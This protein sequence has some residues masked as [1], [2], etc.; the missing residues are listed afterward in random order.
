MNLPHK[1]HKFFILGI[2]F[3][4][5]MPG[6]VGA[7][8]ETKT[9]QI[10]VNYSNFLSSVLK[11]EST[12]GDECKT[13][14]SMWLYQGGYDKA[15]ELVERDKNCYKW[16]VLWG[17]WN[18]DPYDASASTLTCFGENTYEDCYFNC[19]QTNTYNYAFNYQL[20]RDNSWIDLS[21]VN[22]CER[23]R[24]LFF[25]IADWA[26]VFKKS[27]QERKEMINVSFNLSSIL[28]PPTNFLACTDQGSCL[29][30]ATEYSLTSDTFGRGAQKV[31]VDFTAQTERSLTSS[32][33]YMKC[34]D[35]ICISYA[36]GEFPLTATAPASS[37]FG[38]CRGYGLIV[39]TPE[40][41]VPAISSSTNISVAN[42][43]PVVNVTFA[44]NP[45]Q[46]NEEVEVTCDMSDPDTCS[47]KIVKIR[48][49]CVD[50]NGNPDNCYLEQAGGTLLR[51]STVQ[52]IPLINQSNPYQSKI[53]MKVSATGTYAVTCEAWDNDAAKAMSGANVGSVAVTESGDGGDSGYIPS[54]FKN[55]FLFG[56]ERQTDIGIC[57]G[58]N[59]EVSLETV[60]TGLTPVSYDW[61]CGDGSTKKN[62]V[63]PRTTCVYP[64]LSS[65]EKHY[66]PSL[67]INYAGGKEPC[68]TV[69]RVGSYS[70]CG[71]IDERTKQS[72][73]GNGNK[74]NQVRFR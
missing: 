64:L 49:N 5:A 16:C 32:N 27:C 54:R 38:Q 9:G 53:K 72:S 22:K 20:E 68:T 43:P 65:G 15:V 56:E 66:L 41:V 6:K 33:P 39:N 57:P 4:L 23:I 30:Q 47:D 17:G 44:K 2:L 19:S 37:Y 61:E 1:T 29:N 10:T 73:N 21:D 28:S 52:E 40:T 71:V 14:P 24:V 58:R 34:T 12:S 35:S 59:N 8:T 50:G 26:G 46:V 74:S 3:L 36:S 51:G 25:P 70:D 13:T 18:S 63:E 45:L 11:R 55:C 60:Y 69:L 48:W 7:L 42:R 62:T 31:P 67:T